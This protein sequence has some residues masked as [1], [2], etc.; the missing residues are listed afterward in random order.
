MGINRRQWLGLAF[1]AAVAPQRAVGAAVEPGSALRGPLYLAARKLGGNYEAVLL[2]EGGQVLRSV[3]LSGRGHS[4]ALDS[5]SGTVV[6][7]ARQPGTQAVIFS[8]DP[9]KLNEPARV[10]HTPQG[11][12]FSGHGAFSADGQLLYAAEN[13]FEAGRGVIGLYRLNPSSGGFDRVGE[14]ASAGI[15]PH[16][17]ILDV[18]QHRLCVANGGLLTHPDYDKL[19]LNRDTMQA[20]L[21][22]LDVSN[23]QILSRHVLPARQHQQS[24]RHVVLDHRQSAWFGCQ[25]QGSRAHQI[26]LVG[27][28]SGSGSLEWVQ[29]DDEIWH[30]M[31]HYVGSIAFDPITRVVAASSPVGGVVAYWDAASK[32][33]LAMHDLPDGCGVAPASQGG[34]IVNSGFGRWA[35]WRPGMAAPKVLKSDQSV[36]WD[37]HLR[38]L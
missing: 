31:Q 3:R 19:V 7:F 15:G 22:Y 6:A 27:Y 23:G 26:P 36:A 9:G 17:I 35:H 24:I 34:F 28:H 21:A 4:F 10:F 33:F 29:A 12:H 30:A 13:D 38:T 25:Y 14:W 2:T 18:K 37:H 8:C 16:E 20:S 32:T 1:V 11:R 5:S